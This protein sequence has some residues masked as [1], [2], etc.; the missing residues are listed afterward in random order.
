MKQDE[1]KI[2]KSRML[3]AL[4]IAA[5]WLNV[6]LGV[7]GIFL[8]VMPTTVFFLIA[9]ACFAKSSEKFYW[10]LLNNKQFGKLIKD[11]REKRGM[12]LKSKIT[13]VTVLLVVIGYSAIF[14]V[15]SLIISVLLAMIGISV[16]I[17]LIS[18]NTIR[19]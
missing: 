1:L 5:G 4:L 16:S 3:R 2:S 15:D 9:A 12:S 8:P 7:I 18:L 17:Y 6:V 14:A 11:F 13:A 19:D 10:W